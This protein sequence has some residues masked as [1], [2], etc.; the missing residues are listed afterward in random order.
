MKRIKDFL[1]AALLL[2]AVLF[3]CGLV[4][5]VFFRAFGP[6]LASCFD[7]TENWTVEEKAQLGDAIENPL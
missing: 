2:A 5:V 1:H 7:F 6:Y 3:F 4:M